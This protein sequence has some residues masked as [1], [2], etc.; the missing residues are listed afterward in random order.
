MKRKTLQNAICLSVLLCFAAAALSGCIAASSEVPEDVLSEEATSEILAE[1]SISS[2]PSAGWSETREALVNSLLEK[3]EMPG[4]FEVYG[5][6]GSYTLCKIG[7][8]ENGAIVENVYAGYRILSSSTGYPSETHLYFVGDT[9]IYIFNEA[10]TLMLTADMA[11]PIINDM[12]AI[13]ALLPEEMQGGYD[14]SAKDSAGGC[15]VD[16]YGFQNG[17]YRA[18]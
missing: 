18:E 7:S 11:E 16:W 12:A 14:P 10:Y 3:M 15:G 13:Y 8:F 6:V 4:M 9:E 17:I 5:E 2:E 1:A